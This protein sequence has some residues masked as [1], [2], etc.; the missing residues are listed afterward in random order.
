MAAACCYAAQGSARP[1][2][3]GWQSLGCVAGL[4]VAERWDACRV[5]DAGAGIGALCDAFLRR[6]LAG[7]LA[8]RGVAVDAFARS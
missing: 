8:C 1:G 7:G 5:L 4:F 6:W 2:L 3:R